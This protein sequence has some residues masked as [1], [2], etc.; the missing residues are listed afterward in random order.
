MIIRSAEDWRAWDDDDA[1]LRRAYHPSDGHQSALEICETRTK[2]VDSA[3]NDLK[4]LGLSPSASRDR[5]EFTVN[6]PE[7]VSRANF[8]QENGPDR[9]EAT[10]PDSL[11]ASSSSRL[12]TNVMQLACKHPERCVV[13]HTLNHT[14]MIALV[15]VLGS[16]ETSTDA[17]Q[18][19]IAF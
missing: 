3:W 11:I 14:Y 12:T 16:A 7:A 17:V 5:L 2:K 10:P 8:A 9:D 19:A 6:M 18:Q 13:G 4:I 15:E 1:I